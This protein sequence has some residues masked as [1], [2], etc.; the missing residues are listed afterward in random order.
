MNPS[1]QASGQDIG[2]QPAS[3]PLQF[4]GCAARSGSAVPQGQQ[5]QRPQAPTKL[6][7]SP[8]NQETL[9]PSCSH[10]SSSPYASCCGLYLSN[11]HSHADSDGLRLKISVHCKD[12][13]TPPAACMQY[14]GRIITTR[15][16]EDYW[17]DTISVESDPDKFQVRLVEKLPQSAR[18]SV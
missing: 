16:P 14:R 7:R 1:T 4:S 17:G 2:A 11:H 5:Q 10:S 18:L 3:G 8:F 12:L 13:G 15:L 9:T 6:H